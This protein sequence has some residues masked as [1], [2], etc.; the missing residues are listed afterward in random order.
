MDTTAESPME[1]DRFELVLLKR[2][3]SAPPMTDDEI[4]RLQDLHIAHLVEQTNAGAIRVAGPFDEQDDA[5]LRGMALYQTG[6]LERTRSLASSDP[7]VIA[8]RLEID[9]MYFY[10]PKGQL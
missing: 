8:G 10:C 6:S 5:T 3:D 1:L 7:S 4:D 2:P 9:V